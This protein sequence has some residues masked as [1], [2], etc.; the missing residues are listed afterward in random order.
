M[1]AYIVDKKTIDRI[2]SGILSRRK[3]LS[4][5]KGI[6]EIPFDEN[7]TNTFGQELLGLN[8]AAVD[9]RYDENNNIEKYIFSKQPVTPV[10][11]LKSLINLLYQ[12]TEGDVT[13]SILYKQLD[14][15][16]LVLAYIIV[17]ES[18]SYDKAEWG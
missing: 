7:D 15:L 11:T 3:E 16:S 17:T 12:C 4:Y 6:P 14:K 9:Q 5:Q 2:I 1:S 8:K 13:E 18:V 10:Q